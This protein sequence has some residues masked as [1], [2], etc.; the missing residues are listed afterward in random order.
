LKCPKCKKVEMEKKRYQGVEIDRCPV[1]QGIFLDK[2]ELE[3]LI[4]ENLGTH[5]DNLQEASGYDTDEMEAHCPRCRKQML[6]L[7]GPGNIN[8]DWCDSCEAVFLD[9]GELASLQLFQ[10]EDEEL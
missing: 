8:M 5:A 10:A 7:E 3:H 2:G 9:K 1:C 6:R 4:E